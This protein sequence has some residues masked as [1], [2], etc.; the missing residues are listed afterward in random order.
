MH[1]GSQNPIERPSATETDLEALYQETLRVGGSHEGWRGLFEAGADPVETC[2][3]AVSFYEVLIAGDFQNGS[4][5]RAYFV[6]ITR[7]AP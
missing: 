2:K 5:V 3:T 4:A 1:S 6:S 7:S